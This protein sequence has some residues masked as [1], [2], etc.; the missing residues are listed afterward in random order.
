[1]ANPA[2]TRLRTGVATLLA[3]IAAANAPAQ[4]Q[5]ADELR[6]WFGDPF[7]RISSAIPDCPVPAGPFITAA[8]R[9]AESHRRAE[10]GT[11][12]WLAG[13]CERPNAYAY[14]Q[15]I[16][17]AFRSALAGRAGSGE[18]DPFEDTSLWVRVQGRVV[19]IEGCAHDEGVAAKAEAFARALP[20]VEQAIANVRTAPRARPPYRVMPAR[21]P[22]PRSPPSPGP[23]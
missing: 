3:C 21:P 5:E 14:D 22:S 15:D 20:Y 11:T 17:A 4:A 6:N 12:C 18:A 16:A 10:K 23:R 8:E 2:T 7:F 13:Q 9:R 1:M 19:L